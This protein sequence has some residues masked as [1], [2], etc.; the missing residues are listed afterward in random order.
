MGLLDLL[1]AAA[2]ESS[3]HSRLGRW[4]QAVSDQ[5]DSGVAVSTPADYI[6]SKNSAQQAFVAQDNNIVVDQEI[7]VR[8]ITRPSVTVF[9]LTPGKTYHLIAHARFNTFSDQVQGVLALRWV[10]D[11]NANIPTTGPD[12]IASRHLPTTNTDVLSEDPV[13]EV[14]YTVPDTVAGSQVKLR[15]TSAT[16]TATLPANGVSV[17]I[18]E[19][20]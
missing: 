4:R 1:K 12:A 17:T 9:Q 16:G 15:C 14:I 2:G 5:I 11:S 7:N 10:D 3:L 13:A 19:I 20:K 8:G 6:N 18:V